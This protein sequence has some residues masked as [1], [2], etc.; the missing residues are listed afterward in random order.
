MTMLELSKVLGV[1][2]ATI[3]RRLKASSI[4]IE[5]LRD[6]KQLTQHGVQVVSS[7]FDSVSSRVA[8]VSDGDSDALH[9]ALRDTVHG[10]TVEAAVLAAQ[11]AGLQALVAQLEGERD[12]LRRQLAAMTAALER[13]QQDRHRERLLLT[14]GPDDTRGHWWSRWRKK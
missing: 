8:P 3:Y 11:V 6:G 2:T 4:S 9:E 1:S 10:D 12:D 5:D 14:G 13:E 7:M